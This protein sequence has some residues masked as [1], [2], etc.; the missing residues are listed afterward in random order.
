MMAMTTSSSIRVKPVGG[1]GGQRPYVDRTSEGEL[2]R[3]SWAGDTRQGLA[4]LETHGRPS[5]AYDPR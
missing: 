1:G 5:M 2:Q 4:F 3:D